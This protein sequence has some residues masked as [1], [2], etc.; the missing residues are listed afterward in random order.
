MLPADENPL[1]EE[2][3]PVEPGNASASPGGTQV[4]ELADA[5]HV[6]AEGPSA[7]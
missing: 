1:D 5:I 4:Q 6:P 2:E 3:V 7:R